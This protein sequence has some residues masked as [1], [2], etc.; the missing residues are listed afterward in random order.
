MLLVEYKNVS[1]HAWASW[2]NPR[3]NEPSKFYKIPFKS[4]M[5]RREQV[6]VWGEGEDINTLKSRNRAYITSATKQSPNVYKPT[7]NTCP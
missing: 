6:T 4:E 2:K 5:G 3:E 7:A 1:L